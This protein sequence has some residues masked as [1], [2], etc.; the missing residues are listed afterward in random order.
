VERLLDDGVLNCVSKQRKRYYSVDQKK[1]FF[2]DGVLKMDGIG[3]VAMGYFVVVKGREETIA[4]S[5]DDYEKRM[6]SGKFFYEQ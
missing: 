6:K 4:K 1:V 5:I 2:G 3:D